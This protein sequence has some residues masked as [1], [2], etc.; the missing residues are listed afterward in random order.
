MKIK[1]KTTRQQEIHLP[2]GLSEAD[3]LIKIHNTSYDNT[4]AF[5]KIK[6]LVSMYPDFDIT[7]AVTTTPTELVY[8]YIVRCVQSTWVPQLDFL[9]EAGIVSPDFVSK[10][11]SPLILFAMQ[12]SVEMFRY[13]ISRGA[14]LV[15]DGDLVKNINTPNIN[16]LSCA[17]GTVDILQALFN[18]GLRGVGTRVTNRNTLLALLQLGVSLDR[19]H[20]QLREF[21]RMHHLVISVYKPLTPYTCRFK[22]E[23]DTPRGKVVALVNSG[24][25]SIDSFRTTG[26]GCSPSDIRACIAV[27]MS[28]DNVDTLTSLWN[29]FPQQST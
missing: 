13:M 12:N 17:T 22:L 18:S 21:I 25:T 7:K 20:T 2:D 11:G 19:P 27:A 8:E 28:R 14:K 10:N 23:D 4:S 5:A 6:A 16:A 29:A 1:I 26:V 9:F 3:L 24:C 15:I